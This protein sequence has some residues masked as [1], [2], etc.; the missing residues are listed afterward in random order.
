MKARIRLAI[1]LPA[2][3]SLPLAAQSTGFTPEQVMNL[4]QVSN[5]V[6]GNG[7]AAFTRTEPR[8]ASD[9]PGTAYSRL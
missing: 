4:R 5:V 8:P 3:A 6:I 2:L 1:L 7:W 9:G